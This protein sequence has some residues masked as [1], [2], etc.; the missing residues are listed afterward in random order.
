MMRRA[1]V[2]AVLLLVAGGTAPVPQ[3]THDPCRGVDLRTCLSRT[4]TGW[5]E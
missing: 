1:M 5:D 2:P 3:N 4:T